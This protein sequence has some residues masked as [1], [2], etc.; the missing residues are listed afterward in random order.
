MAAIFPFEWQLCLLHGSYDNL[1]VS[2][3]SVVVLFPR[4]VFICCVSVVMKCGNYYGTI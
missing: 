3:V 2:I 1:L 4:V